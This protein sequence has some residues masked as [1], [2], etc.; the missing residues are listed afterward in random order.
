M[1][2]TRDA[3]IPFALPSIGAEEESA[4]IGVLRSGWLTTGSVTMEFE[5]EFARYVS[6]PHALAVNSATS[7]LHLAMECLGVGQGD[8]VITSPYTFAATAET[9]RYLG[10]DVAFADISPDS[11]NIDPGQ[12]ERIL[13]KASSVKAIVPVH[14]GGLP[15]DMD[16]LR[17]MARESGAKII[18]DAAHA[19]PVRTPQGMAGT[20]GDIGVYS[21]YA[22]KTITTGEGG[23]VVTRDEACAKRM[24]TMRLH[25]IDR[26][27]WDRYTSKKA[28][29]QYAIVAPGFKYNLPDV[30]S[31]IGR[32][33]LKKAD[34]F[35]ESR[36]RI[37]RLY[38]GAFADRDYLIPPPSSP[39]HAWHLYSLRLKLDE[40]G[41]GRDEYAQRMQDA[42][43]GISVHFIP[44]H[45]M[46][47]WSDRYG[48]KPEDF[49]QA[50]DRF[51]STIS[52][53]IWPGMSDE[54]VERVIRTAL[55]IGDSFRRRPR[56]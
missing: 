3:F 8:T 28:S 52:L 19:F 25:G 2:E 22:T 34:A 43:I 38:S 44:L 56:T 23:M 17:L 35:L 39:E 54:Q 10:A 55:S 51:L 13:K 45:M 41:I 40:L 49:P 26:E 47:Y 7:G 36:R 12:V 42:G 21:F 29:W 15:C 18:E 20:L 11:Y 37:A 50:R 9:A 1:P 16:R 14:V 32:E 4:V 31:A 46:P 53:P 5:R 30:L 6:S 24:R 33:Q 48:L 27:A